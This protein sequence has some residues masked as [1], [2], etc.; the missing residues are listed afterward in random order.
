MS[1]NE[2]IWFHLYMCVISSVIYRGYRM[3]A[4]NTNDRHH[5][6]RCAESAGKPSCRAAVCVTAGGRLT[7]TSVAKNATPIACR[8]SPRFHRTLS[9]ELG[10]GLTARTY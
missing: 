3:F 4:R 1:M 6:W 7:T 5:S 10:R 8:G 9:G 2:L